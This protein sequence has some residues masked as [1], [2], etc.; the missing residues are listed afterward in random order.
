MRQTYNKFA[1]NKQHEKSVGA[2]R[3]TQLVTSYGCGAIVDFVYDTVIIAG[4]DKWD[5]SLRSETNPFILYNENLQNLLNK[6]YFVKPKTDTKRKAIFVDKSKDIPAYRF[7]EVLHC[8]LCHRLIKYSA[9]DHQQGTKLKCICGSDK[10]IPPRF[11][12]AC[13]NGHIEDFPYE[14]WVHKGKKCE[15]SDS[16]K[17]KMF[18]VNGRTSIDNLFVKC[19]SCGDKRSM[20]GAF[21]ENALVNII[22][23][24]GNSPWL[25]QNE[26][27]ECHENLRTLLRTATNVFFSATMSALKI[28]PWSE[29]V[30]GKL[31][32]YYDS[33]VTNPSVAR[34]IIE[35]SIKPLFPNLTIEDILLAF[36]ELKTNR[37][38]G[39]G[40]KSQYDIF[41][42][43]YIALRKKIESSDEFSSEEME[44]PNEYKS[45]IK[46]VT[47]VDKLT[48]TV[49]MIGFTRI[50]S[51]SGKPDDGKLAHL[52]STPKNWLPAIQN[53][54]EGIFIEFDIE[55][56]EKWANT[57][58]DYYK[59]MMDTLKDSFYINEKASAEYVFLHTFS[60]LLI[61]QLALACGYGAASLKEK[62]YSTFCEHSEFKMAGVLVYTASS[63]ADG[64]LGGL[65]EQAY[66]DKL[67]A[68]IRN[69]LSEAQWCSSDPLCIASNGANGQGVNSMNYAACHNCL[70][71]P[72]TSCEFRNVFLDRAA[73]VGTPEKRELGLFS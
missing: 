29:K 7:P 18:N 50:N 59:P 34:I 63:D 24:S 23:C 73:L 62:I 55:V 42:D 54:G 30:M 64:S 48:E 11:V 51:W 58:R 27:K 47:A 53:N 36:D 66:P 37:V 21:S 14:L 13:E 40:K 17:L 19:E 60:H 61:R 2:V 9:I 71:L 25:A 4:T 52:S 31:A 35:N 1:T 3:Q 39:R 44:V 38:Q 32:I 10:I 56:I 16:P 72:E 15:K 41:R 8:T 49:A 5:W 22:K 45:V 20:Q 57:V 68:I 69:M 67:E 65:V 70:L 12:V 28:P 33:L 26:K 43:E 46:Y 6:D